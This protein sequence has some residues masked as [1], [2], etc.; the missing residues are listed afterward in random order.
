MTVAL[1]SDVRGGQATA[2]RG[3]GGGEN[4]WMRD[5]E[6]Y[7][8]KQI[9]WCPCASDGGVGGAAFD[10]DLHSP[11]E[12]QRP[13]GWNQIKCIYMNY[14]HSWPG[15]P[16][17]WRPLPPSIGSTPSAT[18][19]T[20]RTI[21]AARR[22]NTAPSFACSVAHAPS[23]SIVSD[24]LRRRRLH[25][26]LG[27]SLT[28]SDVSVSRSMVND[29]APLQVSSAADEIE[30]VSD[31]ESSVGGVG[32]GRRRHLSRDR[33]PAVPG[34]RWAENVVEVCA[35]LIS[36]QLDLRHFQR[37]IAS[38]DL[39]NGLLHNGDVARLGDVSRPSFV[40]VPAPS[41][42][43][44]LSN[45]SRTNARSRFGAPLHMTHYVSHQTHARPILAEPGR[46]YSCGSFGKTYW[47]SGTE[48]RDSQAAHGL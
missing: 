40:A 16:P 36:N 37:P 41:A 2:T 27:P 20:A 25:L 33:E 31:S 45:E 21:C 12:N 15:E 4:Q 23:T 34:T 1:S 11:T 35:D 42:S 26:C 19:R 28:G 18:S 7:K 6:I 30:A 14:T 48:K 22:L 13:R 17:I 9:E 43:A 10:S 32:G 47:E 5:I 3:V 29:S 8:Y 39:K 44:Y 38:G 24:L 46:T